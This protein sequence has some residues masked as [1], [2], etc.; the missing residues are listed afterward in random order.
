VKVC[1]RLE[2]PPAQVLGN[3]FLDRRPSVFGDELV[4]VVDIA[5]EEAENGRII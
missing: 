1:D 2:A 3:P 4:E 5:V